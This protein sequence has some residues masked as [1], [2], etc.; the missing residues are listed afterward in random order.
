MSA[1]RIASLFFLGPPLTLYMAW[2]AF[3]DAVLPTDLAG[4]FVAGGGVLLV[5][6]SQRRRE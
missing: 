5:V 4:L 6:A 1:T 2:I 3:G